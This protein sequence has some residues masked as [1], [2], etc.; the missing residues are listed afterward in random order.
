MGFNKNF[1]D[2]FRLGFSIN[3]ATLKNKVISVNNQLGYEIGGSFGIGG[4]EGPSRMEVGF[5]MGFFYGFNSDGIFHNQEEVVAHASYEKVGPSA[6]IGDLK[7]LDINM[8]GL[9][10]ED[11]RTNLGNPIPK[12]TMGLNFSFDYK[13][14]DFQSYF[15]SSLGFEIVRNYERNNPLTNRTSYTLNRWTGPGNPIQLLV[16]PLLQHQILYFL[17]FMLKMAHLFELRIFS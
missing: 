7:F 10:T 6:S 1:N 15:F 5:P 2:D 14:F 11:D 17:I 9:I 16:L 8:D 3:A 13:N 4:L 12:L